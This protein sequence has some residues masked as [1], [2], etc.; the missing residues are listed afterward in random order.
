MRI[1][2]L[3][4]IAAAALALG[5]PSHAAELKVLSTNAFKTA[6]EDLGPKFEKSSGD[7]LLI[8]WGTAAELKGQIEKG[9]AFDVAV[10]T[11]AGADDLIKQG[12]LAA[13]T[14]LARS[15]IAVAIQKGAPKPALASADDFKKMVLA[16]KSIAWVEQGASGIYLKG[17]FERLGISDEIKGKLKPVKAAGEAVAN[18]EAEIGFTQVS[19]I[20]PYPAAEVG[21]MLPPD[22]QSFT[23][24]SVGVRAKDSEPAA[25]LVKFLKTEAAADVIKAK[26]LEPR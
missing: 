6:L 4:L 26:G 13:R 1:R 9:A 16:A 18:H 23:S 7:K 24:F 25:A 15:G 17:V 20:L 22:I 10:I 19:E 21:G 14:P 12:K 5:A 8:T 3:L 11:D 2:H